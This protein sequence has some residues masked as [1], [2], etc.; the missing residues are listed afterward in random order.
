M[1]EME[2][3]TMDISYKITRRFSE[4]HTFFKKIRKSMNIKCEFP[5][6]T[7]NPFVSSTHGSIITERSS[8]L[9]CNDELIKLF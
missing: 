5:K 1:Y 3:I 2:V 4:F 8:K 7:Y 6:K 9:H